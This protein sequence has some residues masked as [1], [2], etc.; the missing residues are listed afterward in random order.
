VHSAGVAAVLSKPVTYTALI[1]AIAR[2]VGPPEGPA[3]KG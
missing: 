1:E 3:R 2:I